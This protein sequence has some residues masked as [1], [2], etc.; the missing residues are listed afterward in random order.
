MYL[1]FMYIYYDYFLSF[2]F[3][4][5]DKKSFMGSTLNTNS[6]SRAILRNDRVCAPRI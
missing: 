5:L 1:L 3:F 2:R 4:I 6:R